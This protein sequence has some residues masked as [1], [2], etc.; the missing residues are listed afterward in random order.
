M[1]SAMYITMR[2]IHLNLF[3]RNFSLLRV[4]AVLLTNGLNEI[5]SLSKQSITVRIDASFLV[6]SS[7]FSS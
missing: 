6:S 7:G 1:A 4:I 2:Q 3:L 5:N